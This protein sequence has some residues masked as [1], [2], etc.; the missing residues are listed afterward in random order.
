MSNKTKIFRSKNLP[1][2]VF[3]LIFGGLGTFLIINSFAATA[4]SVYLTPATQTISES[5]EF[6]V[7]IRENSGTN[8]VNAIQANLSYPST[9]LDVVSV[10][11][12]TAA[13]RVEA[14]K[15]FANGTIKLGLGDADSPGSGDQL[16]AVIRFKSKTTAGVANVSFT[17]GTALIDSTTNSDLLGTLNSTTAPGGS[18]TV[19]IET[20]PSAAVTYPTSG[21]KVRG[22]VSV[23]GTAFDA[24]GVA[25]V[26]FKLDGANLGAADTTPPYSTSWNSATASDGSH[27]ITAVATDTGNQTTTSSGVTFTVDN[28]APVTTITSANPGSTT[29]TSASFTFDTTPAETGETYE[30][31]LDTGSWASCTSPK[32][33]SGLAVG[34]HTF[35]VRATDS[36]GNLDATPATQT[37]TVTSPADTTAPTV[38]ITAPANNA[39]VSGS[40]VSVTATAADTVGVAGVKFYL[41]QTPPNGQLGNEDTTSPYSTTLDT[42]TLANG[43]HTLRAVARDAAGN[44]TTSA[45]I[46]ISVNNVVTPTPDV[47]PPT[48]PTNLRSTATSENSISL[49]WNSSTDPPGALNET[50]SGVNNYTI[51]RS[52]SAN[53]TYTALPAVTATSL[54][55]TG[56]TASTTY[57]Y[58][59][60]ASDN[61]GKSSAQSTS[62]SATT[63]ATPAPVPGDVDG[64]RTVDILDLG[65][66]LD[67]W[68][69]NYP[70]A[71]FK[72][73]GVSF[74][75]IDIYDLS[76][77]LSNY[78]HNG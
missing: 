3:A 77:L 34:S 42:T 38:S 1:I 24:Q 45:V 22:T 71:D 10:D 74:N 46:T 21:A 53:G 35:N 32:A 28:T 18:Y 2:A 41:D 52:N 20:A 49:A 59:V 13:F 33:Y 11:T 15:S 70:P 65:Q 25:N 68:G 57:Y 61:A 60:L 37:W 8:T 9:L 76:I 69:Q 31:Q 12:S 14:E 40:N 78:G 67:R 23:T 58:K 29:Q 7:E 6:T 64:N 19:I 73:D 75:K 17:S 51:Y 26:Q 54:V 4:P 66:L 56:L 44:T 30:C 72:K 50:V 43:S 62:I 48:V 47:T 55:N 63:A 39:T 16:V 5:T 36:T 27:T